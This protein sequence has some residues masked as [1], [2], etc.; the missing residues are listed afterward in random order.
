MKKAYTKPELTI[1]II[2]AD[3]I[4][5]ASGITFSNSTQSSYNTY[6]GQLFS[7]EINF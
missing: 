1:Q 5:T 6:D 2:K 3:D 7:T 4:I